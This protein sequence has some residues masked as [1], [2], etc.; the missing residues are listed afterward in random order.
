MPTA[1]DYFRHATAEPAPACPDCHGTGELA[2]GHECQAC[3]GGPTQVPDNH[4]PYQ[5]H[6][7]WLPTGHF[8]GPGKHNLNPQLFD[9]T[10]LRPEIRQELLGLLNT[11]WAPKYGDTWQTWARVYLAGSA[12]SYWWGDNN[13]L[14]TL[15]GIDYNHARRLCRPLSH[16][17]DREIDDRLNTEFREGLNNDHRTLHANG[18][19]IGPL[20]STFFVNSDAFDVRLLRPYAAYDLTADT[21]A[22]EPVQ[23][24]D[25]FSA[26]SLPES[27]WDELDAL[28]RQ[29]EEIAKLP[30]GEREARG[31]ELYD[32]L[33]ADRHAAFTEAG[34]GLYDERNVSWKALDA[35]PGHPLNQLAEWKKAHAGAQPTEETAA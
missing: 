3:D 8:F 15:V 4:Q 5:H 24:P 18:H 19:D 29:V 23:V 34:E 22:V 6:H 13:D 27:D 26:K 28:R 12:I 25:D 1:A 20:E 16:L 14:D 9:G 17:T 32:K 10:H 21:W 2:D 7:D 33:H 30:E 11:F 31:A 35:A